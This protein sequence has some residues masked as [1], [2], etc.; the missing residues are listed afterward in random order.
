MAQPIGWRFVF[1]G[2]WRNL[3]C[4]TSDVASA[5]LAIFIGTLRLAG[6][7]DALVDVYSIVFEQ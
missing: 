2:R 7:P 4:T 5:L 1:G 6:P 3:S